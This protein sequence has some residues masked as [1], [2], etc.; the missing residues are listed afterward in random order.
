MA[1]GAVLVRSLG[2]LFLSMTLGCGVREIPEPRVP[3]KEAPAVD[4]ADRAPAPHTG[5]VV[6]DAVGTRARVDEIVALEVGFE[7]DKPVDGVV[8]DVETRPLCT[9]TPCVVDLGLGP[10]ILRYSTSRKTGRTSLASLRVGEGRSVFRHDLGFYATHRTMRN[11]GLL[12]IVAGVV[13]TG[14]GGSLFVMSRL[15]LSDFAE[16][17]EAIQPKLSTSGILLSVT[18]VVLVGAGVVLAVLGRDEYQR[19][20][21]VHFMLPPAPAK[22]MAPARSP[23]SPK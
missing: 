18:G 23:S 19:G 17:A 15:P 10:H 14:V 11:L 13:T 7:G 6:L 3:A 9:A 2:A 12:S 8:P 16:G 22:V 5:L 4:D 20:S 1:M 21:S